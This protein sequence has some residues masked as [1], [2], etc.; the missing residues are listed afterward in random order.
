M[1][2]KHRAAV[3]VIGTVL[4]D[5]LDDCSSLMAVLCGIG[6]YVHFDLLDGFRVRRNHRGAIPCLAVRGHTVEVVA[7]GL[8]PRA[9]GADLNGILSL[10][11]STVRT[12]HTTVAWQIRGTS[13]TRSR[14]CSKHTGSQAEQLERIASA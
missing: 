2:L 8:Q 9:V 1:D 14:A 13:V 11:N 3:K 10:E 6:A 5:H 4:R 12:A 7:V